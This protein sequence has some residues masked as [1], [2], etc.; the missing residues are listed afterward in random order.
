MRRWEDRKLISAQQ[1]EDLVASL[2][3]EHHGGQ[4]LR[5]T[6]NVNSADGGIDLYLVLDNDASLKRA[7]QVKRRITKDGEPIEEVRNFVGAMLLSEIERVIFVT[8][9]SRF[10]K[11]A[12]SAPRQAKEAKVKLQLN[13]VDGEMLLEM[14]RTTN[15]TCPVQLPPNVQLDQEWRCSTGKLIP[16]RELFTGDIREWAQ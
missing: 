14:L 5:T 1:A 6:A 13:L 8:T 12:E 15:S 10:T 2:L 3:E 9:A 16:A 7:G 4:V 11:V